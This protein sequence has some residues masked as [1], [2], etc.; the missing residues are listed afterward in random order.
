MDRFEEIKTVKPFNPSLAN[1]NRFISDAIGDNYILVH[2]G[3][4]ESVDAAFKSSCEVKY[5]R[6]I[7][8]FYGGKKADSLS[9]RIDIEITTPKFDFILNIRN[10]SGKVYPSHLMLDYKIKK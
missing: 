9:K 7:K 8:I 5:G 2:T 1:Y 6:D 4:V 10:K 3:H